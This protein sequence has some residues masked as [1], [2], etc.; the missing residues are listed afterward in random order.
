MKSKVV[1]CSTYICCI[2][3]EAPFN[4]FD[5]TE[6]ITIK[7]KIHQRS[8][9]SHSS[10]AVTIRRDYRDF[11]FARNLKISTKTRTDV[12]FR[13]SRIVFACGLSLSFV[14]VINSFSLL[15]TDFPQC[16]FCRLPLLYL[17]YQFWLWLFSSWTACWRCDS[18]LSR[19]FLNMKNVLLINW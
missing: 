4:P 15:P 9:I 16:H 6:I 8:C 7:A 2:L 5:F 3:S 10:S 19:P 1:S 12:I 18:A 11:H 13:A 17:G 14:L